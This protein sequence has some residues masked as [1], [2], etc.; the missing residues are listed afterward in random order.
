MKVTID[1]RTYEVPKVFTYRELKLLK[2]LTGLRPMELY[3]AVTLRDPDAAIGMA[4]IC[5]ARAGELPNNPSSLYDKEAGSIT[6]DLGDDEETDDE[7]DEEG[8]ERPPAAAAE[9]GAPPAGRRKQARS[10]ARSPK[11]NGGPSA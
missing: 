5:L 11:T 7:A 4:A 3:E 8:D 1:D 10:A 6:L 2:S 9:T